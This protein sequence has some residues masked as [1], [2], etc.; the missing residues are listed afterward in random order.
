M[1]HIMKNISRVSQYI[2]ASLF[3][4]L[5]ALN[6]NAQSLYFDVNGTTAGYGTAAAG[7]YSWDDPNW[8]TAT[9]GTNATG[10]WVAGSFA[11]F[12][13]TNSYTVTV[14]GDEQNAGLVQAPAVGTAANNILT[15]N[16]AGSGT[17]DVLPASTLTAGLPAQGF[18]CTSLGKL[19]I[20][21]PISGTGALNL[22]LFSGTGE[23]HLDG[24][25]TYSGGTALSTSSYL[26]YFNNSN[27]FGTGPI[28]ING[29]TFAALLSEGGTTIT[30]PNNWTNV[31]VAGTNGV[32]FASSAS[33][34]VICTG[35]WFLQ[36]NLNLRNNGNSTAP[37]TLSGPISGSPTPALTLSAN[38]SGKVILSG[39]NIYTGK[40]MLGGNGSSGVTL[41]ISSFNSVNNGQPSS[42]LGAPTTVA[43]GTISIGSAAL[44][45]TLIYTGPGETTDR[46][47]DL[48]GTTGGATLQADGTG[49]LVFT[50]NFSAS[51]SGAKTLTLQGSSAVSNSIKGAI[52]DSAAGGT[53]VTK[54][55]TGT[56][57]LAG[58]NTYSRGT[59]LT[60]GQLNIGSATALSTGTFTNNGSGKFDNTTGAD[61]T[62]ANTA[63]ALTGGFHYVGSSNNVTLSNP[64]L[65]G[66]GANRNVIV[67][68]HT[69]TLN[70]LG[71]DTVGNGFNKGGVGTL[72]MVGTAGYTGV[73]T[74]NANGGTMEVDGNISSSSTVNVNGGVL[75]GTGT[76]PSVTVNS[77]GT[78]APGDGV[79]TISSGNETWNGGGHYTWQINDAA[80]AA[81]TGY[82][83]IAING[84][85]NI[86]ATS[87]NKFNIDLQSLSGTTPGD[88]ANFGTSGQWTLATASG[89]ITG[90]SSSAL[91]INTNNFSN[92][93]GSNVFVVSVSADSKSLL[94]NLVVPVQNQ[95]ATGPGTG[96]F[97]GSPNTS[98][99]VQFTDS[100]DSPIN[101][102][103][104]TVVTTDSNGV[105]TYIDPGPLPPE[106]FYRISTP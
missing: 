90:F 42:N 32:N 103:T 5:M 12:L 22:G 56:W 97:T 33:T 71:Q 105:G 8:A 31:A 28:C 27:S 69:L 10:A 40:T 93:T 55:G 49:P 100:L 92:S 63:L 64:L 51:G 86:S 96:T 34:P 65:S 72:I 78:I 106:R 43:D 38:N 81:G 18:F 44:T 17:L 47:I 80:A 77:G 39:A 52:V 35:S 36:T 6:V 14:N 61:L 29:T 79:G 7:T 25:N 23:I 67:D 83:T 41:S 19:F 3:L 57:E 87:T 24:T 74:L 59:S 98:Y 88:A 102:Q 21:A 1:A 94:L 91:S 50:S 9:G 104:L 89:G 16:A 53:L 99:T 95:T 45:S 85:L 30:I 70:A 60:A 58:N 73:T 76:T 75:Q 46:V 11:R 82:D 15:I 54:S 20:T 2:A 66:S 101:W 84:T 68:G 37:L 26:I 13:G 62:I 48:S 4:T